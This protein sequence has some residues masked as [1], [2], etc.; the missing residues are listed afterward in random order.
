MD[1]SDIATQI[2]NLF[3]VKA[4]TLLLFIMIIG[5]AAN[6]GAR[7]IPDNAVGFWGAVRKVC[8]IIG[9]YI[10]SRV[11][12]GVTVNDVAAAALKTP[13]IP[14]KVEAAAEQTPKGVTP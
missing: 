4:S 1:L 8:S 11:S 12:P 3:G 13:P 7:L 6:A 2:A 10:P 9:V 5:T 14:Q